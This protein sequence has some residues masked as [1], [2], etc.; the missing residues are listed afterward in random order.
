MADKIPNDV[1]ARIKQEIILAEKINT[2]ELEPIVREN[3]SRYCSRH[4]PDMQSSQDW[5]VILN[6][7]Y[8]V[9][10]RELPAI[11]FR[12][13][14]VFLKPRNKTFL[15]KRRNPLTG[16]MEETELD[17]MKSARTQEG[18]LNYKLEEIRYKRETQKVLLD[19]LLFQHGVLWHGYKGNF[20][21]TDEKSF[22][23][24]DEDVFVKRL[25]PLKFLKDPSVAMANLEEARWIGRSF[26]VP[27]DDLLSDDVL[28]IDKSKLK[29]RLGYGEMIE[30]KNPGK[31]GV[32][33][34]QDQ[35]QI[36][37]T[38]KPL[39]E[40][41]DKDYQN[42]T[43][44]RFV[45]VYEIFIRPT[46][47]E[48]RNK[49]KGRILLY[50]KEQDKPLRVNEWPYKAKGWPAVVLQFNQLNDDMFGLSDPEVWGRIA[51]QKNMIVNLQLRNAKENSRV[52]M[53]YD[54]NKMSQEEDIEKIRNG[55][56]TVVGFDGNPNECLKI[57]S[58]SGIG[59]GEL[60]QLDGRIQRNL[61]DK[62]GV[63]ELAR[64]FLQSGEES[65]TSVEIRSQG[66]SARPAYR[67]DI[68]SDFIS[69]SVHYLN[70]L[71]KQFYPVDKAVR[72]IGSLD[73]EWCDA[74]SKEEIQAET[75]VEIDVLSM[76]PENPDKE[77]Q[78]MQ[79]ILTL[80]YQALT[81][82][83]IIQKIEQEGM[84]INIAP[85]IENLLIR[86]RVRN[87]DVFRHVKP[88]E[89]QGYASVSE[90]RQAGQNVQSALAGQPPPSPAQPGQDHRARLEVYGNI[91]TILQELG[92]TVAGKILGQLMQ[93]QQMMAQ[94][95]EEKT[96]QVGNKAPN[97]KIPQMNGRIK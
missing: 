43:L 57:I 66:M 27:M 23:I 69:D 62:S 96:A 18:I 5:D 4:V 92:D 34:G 25:S 60:Y 61:E 6:E 51:D 82:P 29:G 28:D 58:P 41:L 83:Q 3:L 84:I 59:S 48:K 52:M 74:P 87:P 67:Q 38:I 35:I 95:E 91:N 7:V 17:S 47:K 1:F 77:L 86:L 42:S 73:V 54:K 81:T 13:P 31:I 10:Q 89:S 36:G 46:L 64:G 93:M 39:S 90:L 78:E 9:I 56:Q 65:A 44:A 15:A 94:E 14:R 21:M 40:F 37:R 19:A 12:N 53:G 30:E 16:V 71:I 2:N 76:L 22:F 85:I 26:E 11:F 79:T 45:T 55:D 32:T 8:P 97:F 80:M 63:T 68:M 49:E 24:E 75:D 70:Q 20:G 33:G 88:E 72:I 50:T